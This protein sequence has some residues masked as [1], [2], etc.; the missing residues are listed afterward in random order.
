M[1]PNLDP[2][3]GAYVARQ[4]ILDA[5]GQVFGYELLYRAAA[6]AVSCQDPR[7][8]AA[9][10]VLNDA[11]LTL[12]LETLTGGRKAFMNVTRHMLLNE[13]V[14]VMA[15]ETIVVEVLEDVGVDEEI[16]A[17]CRQLKE[18]GYS[19]ALDDFTLQTGAAALLPFAR[20]VKV[21]VLATPAD[22]R[23]QIEKSIP[24]GVKLVAEKVE[25]AQV[26][27]EARGLGYG[28][29]QGYYFCR[30]TTFAGG[31]LSARRLAYARLLAALNRPNVSVN[32][33]E[34]LIKHD[35]SLTYRVLRC[36]NSAAFGIRREIQSIRQALVLLGL[37][38]VRKWASVWALAGLNGGASS[39]I[40][41]IAILR[42]RSCEIVAAEAIG[43][44]HA[45][46]F[47]LL[48]L[49]SLLDAMLGQPMATAVAELPLSDT[50]RGAL[51]GEQNRARS[52][53]DA[54]I[55]HERGEWDEAARI[56]ATLPVKAE[57][58]PAAYADSLK[59]ARE[60]TQVAKAA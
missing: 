39:E 24:K 37:E 13:L 48:G 17:A 38:Q 20:Y 44:D 58:L 54:V 57:R 41:T 6:D 59:W 60:L 46:E 52:V 12:G 53:L 31:A 55:A 7:D 50:V 32:S 10:R 3:E 47:F 45:S 42:A 26:F 21:D 34:D 51:L 35:A 36:I 19:L 23:R 33:V 29:F 11:V 28:L 16:I 2:R 30:P 27:D 25:S 56:A 43:Q 15:P 14:T 4:P 1:E 49:C 40:V 18:R 8:L 9:A 5:S 22:E